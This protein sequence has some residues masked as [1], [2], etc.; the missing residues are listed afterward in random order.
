MSRRPSRSTPVWFV[1]SATRLPATTPIESDSSTSIPGRT[2]AAAGV[3]GRTAQAI[4]TN[5]ERECG[6]IGS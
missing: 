2:C 1:S 3:G 6:R 5:S 4:T